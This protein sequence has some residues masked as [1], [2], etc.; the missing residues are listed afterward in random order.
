MN[1]VLLGNLV[2]LVGAFLMIAIGLLKKKSQILI[3][4]C[5][6]FGIMGAGHA[7]LGGFSGVVSNIVSIL[8][9][10]ICLKWAFTWPFKIIFI[11]LQ[12]LMTAAVKPVGIIGWL[13]AAAA[14]LYTWFLDLK[15]ERLLK[16]VMIIAQLF[17]IVYDFSIQNYTALA[18]DVFTVISNI[19]GIIMLKK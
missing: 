17:W 11:V 12:I 7:I 8:R 9:N 4:Q 3:A 5:A 1:P 14:C 19:V 10:V 16:L 2:S 6:Q 18:F 13:P 15:S